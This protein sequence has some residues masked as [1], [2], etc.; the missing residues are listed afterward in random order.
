MR[1]RHG[2][3]RIGWR[4]EMPNHSRQFPAHFPPHMYKLASRW[5]FWECWYLALRKESPQISTI[6]PVIT[7]KPIVIKM[8]SNF[9]NRHVDCQA[10]VDFGKVAGK[11]V[12][13]T[14]G[15]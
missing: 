11:T 9:E 13:L 15:K 3:V 1:G 14:G 7:P 10:N 5:R 8:A 4:E 6:H 2:N 12:V